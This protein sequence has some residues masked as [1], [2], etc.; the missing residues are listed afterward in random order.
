MKSGPLSYAHLGGELTDP[1]RVSYLR[2]RLLAAPHAKASARFY[3][4]VVKTR[5]AVLA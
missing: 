4:E 1:L 3:S 5:G 2:T